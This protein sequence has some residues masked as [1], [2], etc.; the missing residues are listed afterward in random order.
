MARLLTVRNSL[1]LI[2]GVATILLVV[3]TGGTWI[4]ANKQ[5]VDAQRVQ[6]S[7]RSTTLLLRAAFHWAFERALTQAALFSQ[8]PVQSW[9]RQAIEEE[10]R[11]ADQAYDQ[12]L[13]SLPNATAV[14]LSKAL[15]DLNDR[16]TTIGE[17][18][19]QLD[20]SLQVIFSAREKD[21]LVKWFPAMTG[22]IAA[23][24][25]LRRIARFQASAALR[26]VEAL[27]EVMEQVAVMWEF[28]QQ[29]AGLIAGIIAADDPIVLEDVERLAEFR[30]QLMQAWRAV[31]DYARR[32]DAAPII[33][34]QISRMH[35]D[36]FASFERI[37]DPIVVAGM[38]GNLYPISAVEWIHQTDAAIQPIFRLGEM[39]LISPMPNNY[40]NI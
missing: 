6:D 3:L 26:D 13:A 28:A 22:L 15:R 19:A 38:E 11:S 2:A 36:Y 39:M 30:G 12:A 25:Q 18:R 32:P 7:N 33:V 9:S 34:D 14:K 1:I 37:R 24:E 23:N 4:D 40:S 35:E 20:D 8:Q 5:R 16:Y 27:E 17:I 10:R 21:H 29:E 31:E